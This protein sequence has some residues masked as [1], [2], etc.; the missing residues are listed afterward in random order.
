MS[1]NGSLQNEIVGL[2]NRIPKTWGTFELDQLTDAEASALV[3]LVAA[4][5]VERRFE[6]RL[7]MINHP[8][9]MTAQATAT[10]EGGG[11]AALDRLVAGLW[12]E[13]RESYEQWR[14]SETGDSVPFVCERIGK[15]EWRLTKEGVLARGDLSNGSADTVFEYVLKRG[16]F[17]GRDPC[18]GSGR[19]L[20]FDKVPA[21][22]LT[23][24]NGTPVQV[25]NC[26]ELAKAVFRAF[27]HAS[28][29]QT[30]RDP[31]SLESGLPDGPGSGLII[32]EM[33]AEYIEQ[34]K[35]HFHRLVEDA[36]SKNEEALEHFKAMFGPTAIARYW[37]R[38]W[39]KKLRAKVEDAELREQL[40]AKEL[41]RVTAAIKR[42]PLYKQQV[43]G[44]LKGRKPKDWN[45]P[46]K[47]GEEINSVVDEIL[48]KRR[49]S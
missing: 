8:L 32:K 43:E 47:S 29:Q 23:S 48:N 40:I 28:Q 1:G 9:A 27:E 15:D 39:T 13:W 4:G 18:F 14:Q 49:A 5:M 26:D 24:S 25:V 36:L 3:L 7:R 2:L 30:S 38:D 20:K 12:H 22:S 17:A 11:A 31:T 35:Q 33:L 37:L 34:R 45:P 42:Q 21:D 41:N 6:L 10:G 46:T 44:P 19:M 16:F